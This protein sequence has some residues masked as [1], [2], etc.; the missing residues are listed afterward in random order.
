MGVKVGDAACARIRQR[1]SRPRPRT[2]FSWNSSGSTSAMFAAFTLFT[3]PLS[4]L[5][6]ASHAPRWNS[7]EECG[8]EAGAS[9]AAAR[10]RCGGT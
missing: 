5:R 1:T 4:D 10:A 3:T 8:A 6:S 9:A 2:R 7:G